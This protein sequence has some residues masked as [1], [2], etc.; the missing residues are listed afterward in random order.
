MRN[1]G[2][3]QLT[4]KR[5]VSG[6][7]GQRQLGNLQS[8][9]AAQELALPMGPAPVAPDMQFDGTGCPD[10][11]AEDAAGRSWSLL[12]GPATR[13]GDRITIPVSV[14]AMM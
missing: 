13:S 9:H 2:K 3:R 6:I 14:W 10:D 12:P 11:L 7:V 5:E 4:G 1:R 8:R